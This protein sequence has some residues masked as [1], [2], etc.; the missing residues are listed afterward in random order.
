MKVDER[1][2]MLGSDLPVK[3]ITADMVIRHLLAE[4]DKVE[5]IVVGVTYKDGTD[6]TPVVLHSTNISDYFLSFVGSVMLRLATRM[7]DRR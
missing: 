7:M 5:T 4:A 1:S 6:Q 2:K 3:N